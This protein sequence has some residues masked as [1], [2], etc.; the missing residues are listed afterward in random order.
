MASCFPLSVKTTCRELLVI[1]ALHSA[2]LH[3]ACT[4]CK[5]VMAH[6]LQERKSRWAKSQDE[7]KS[8]SDGGCEINTIVITA[9]IGSCK[10]SSFW[11]NEGRIP[12]HGENII[13]I[14]EKWPSAP[15]TNYRSSYLCSFLFKG[16]AKLSYFH[17]QH[18]TESHLSPGTLFTIKRYIIESGE[19]AAHKIKQILERPLDQRQ[20]I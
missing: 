3:S 16:K 18:T 10:L 14:K 1:N 17:C 4:V 13:C 9:T 11:F 5:L 20:M 8:A 7:E 2:H 12:M 19:S 15:S 6:H